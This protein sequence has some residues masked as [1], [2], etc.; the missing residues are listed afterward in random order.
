[1]A[2]PF[3]DAVSVSGAPRIFFLAKG[4]FTNYK[5]IKSF[6]KIICGKKIYVYIKNV[7]KHS[8]K[9]RRKIIKKKQLTKENNR[10]THARK[11]KSCIHLIILFLP[12]VPSGV[13]IPQQATSVFIS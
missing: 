1:M 9:E 11:I 8:N 5:I 10:S 3:H 4:I 13:Y 12:Q 6:E 2:S 7:N